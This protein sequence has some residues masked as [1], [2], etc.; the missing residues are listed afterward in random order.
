MSS[1][2]RLASSLA[3]AALLT[4]CDGPSGTV[5]VNPTAAAGADLAGLAALKVVVRNVEVD[6]PDVFGPFPVDGRE[7]LLPAT[8]PANT[9]FYVDVWGCA[10]DACAADALVGRGCNQV[11]L[12][13]EE[14]LVG[15]L[16]LDIF[17]ADQAE[18]AA[19]PPR[20]HDQE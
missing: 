6:V 20:I 19:C 1:W 16:N 4:A 7:H 8:V 18:F 17:S 10:D 11:L 14:G 15:V 13:L 12:R 2:T 3:V 9:F 5:I